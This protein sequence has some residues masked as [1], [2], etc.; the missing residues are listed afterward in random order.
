MLHV[1]IVAVSNKDSEVLAKDSWDCRHIIILKSSAVKVV[2]KIT[3]SCR[4]EG[5]LCRMVG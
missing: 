1:H 4:V 2:L 5:Q 3:V